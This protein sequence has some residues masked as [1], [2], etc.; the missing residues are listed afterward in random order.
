MSISAKVTGSED[1][2]IMHEFSIKQKIFFDTMQSYKR[3]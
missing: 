1:T 2:K 3:T